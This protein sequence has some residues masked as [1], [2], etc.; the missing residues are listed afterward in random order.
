MRKQ[1][2]LAERIHILLKCICADTHSTERRYVIHNFEMTLYTLVGSLAGSATL[3]PDEEDKFTLTELID[4]YSSIFPLK[5][6][7]V[8]GFYGDRGE[9]CAIAVDECYNFH[10]VKRSKVSQSI[11]N[12]TCQCV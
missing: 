4:S 5:V 8:K 10:F 12:G 3:F 1:E 6:C 7:V 9:D 11:Y 2:N